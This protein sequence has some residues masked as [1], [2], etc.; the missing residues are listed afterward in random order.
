MPRSQP[1]HIDQNGDI[2]QEDFA[3]FQIEED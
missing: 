3:E 2:I 1:Q